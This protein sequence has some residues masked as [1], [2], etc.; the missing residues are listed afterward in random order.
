MFQKNGYVFQ[1]YT[2]LDLGGDGILEQKYRW[3]AEPYFD[4][5][6]F[7]TCLTNDMGAALTYAENRPIRDIE[8][9]KAIEIEYDSIML[10]VTM[11]PIIKHTHLIYE[12]HAAYES[13]A[14]AKAIFGDDEFNKDVKEK[15]AYLDYLFCHAGKIVS[16]S[17]AIEAIRDYEFAC[18]AECEHSG[19]L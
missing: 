10:R 8:M 2:G 5:H 12:I 16:A 19:F 4:E 11:T 6:T 14:N 3:M 18:I 7:M 17:E 15:K 1:V 13:L 9:M